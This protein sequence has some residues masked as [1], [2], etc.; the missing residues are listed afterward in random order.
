MTHGRHK[1]YWQVDGRVVARMLAEIRA[2][3]SS[4]LTMYDRQFL[5]DLERQSSEHRYFDMNN[6]NIHWLCRLHK[7]AKSAA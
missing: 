5:N 3:P 6:G 7:R 4:T 1:N 2:R